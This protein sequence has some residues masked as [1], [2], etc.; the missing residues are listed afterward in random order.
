MEIGPIGMGA[1]IG[2]GAFA[3][4]RSGWWRL[5]ERRADGSLRTGEVVTPGDWVQ[6][7][8]PTAALGA[9]AFA[10]VVAGLVN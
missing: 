10:A 5:H 7:W 2:I 8:V 4:C 9:F 3:F 6:K 1:A